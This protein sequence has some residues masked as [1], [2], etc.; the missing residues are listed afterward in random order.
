VGD[1]IYFVL[2]ANGERGYFSSLR[3]EGAGEA[4]IYVVNMP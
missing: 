3:D 2:S 1:D 4:D